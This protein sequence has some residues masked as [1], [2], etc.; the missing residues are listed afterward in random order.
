MLGICEAGRNVV[1]HGIYFKEI[2]FLGLENFQGNQ[3]GQS[4]QTLR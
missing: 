3:T 1:R 2:L 4:N